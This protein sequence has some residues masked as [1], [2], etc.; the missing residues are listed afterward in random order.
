MSSAQDVTAVFDLSAPVQTSQ[1]IALPTAPGMLDMIWV[2]DNSGS[3]G[4]EIAHVKKNIK[5]FLARLKA[6]TASNINFMLISKG[7]T[8]TNTVESIDSTIYSEV[9]KAGGY[10]D[11]E[12]LSHNSL[13]LAALATCKDRVSSTGVSLDR[14]NKTIC[15]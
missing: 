14:L 6:G 8:A 11:F 5:S 12:V 7:G 13:T 10:V 1:T 4:N 9:T 2:I 3:M 15:G